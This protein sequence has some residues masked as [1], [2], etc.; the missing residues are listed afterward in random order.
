MNRS[1]DSGRR[2]SVRAGRISVITGLISDP[3]MLRVLHLIGQGVPPA[4]LAE[5]T[6]MRPELLTAALTRLATI[7]LV[8]RERREGRPCWTLDERA[9]AWLAQGYE[10]AASLRRD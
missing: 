10:I 3:R 5:R 6:G 1:F 2:A 9:A 4:E 8:R 7:G